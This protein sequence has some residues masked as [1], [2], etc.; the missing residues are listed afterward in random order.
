MFILDDQDALVELGEHDHERDEPDRERPELEHRLKGFHRFTL[1][2]S[3]RDLAAAP[4]TNR[5]D[6]V[7]RRVHAEAQRSTLRLERTTRRI[8]AAQLVDRAGH[9]LADVARRFAPVVVVF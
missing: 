9:H 5:A 2:T 7:R 3:R 8:S 1:H 6:P 4:A